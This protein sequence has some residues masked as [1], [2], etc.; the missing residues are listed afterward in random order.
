MNSIPKKLFYNFMG[1]LLTANKLPSIDFASLVKLSLKHPQLYSH[2]HASTHPCP[3]N[4]YYTSQPTLD[5]PTAPVNGSAIKPT[6]KSNPI[7]W[8]TDLL[9]AA[10][11]HH[12]ANPLTQ[13]SAPHNPKHLR[14]SAKAANYWRINDS[15][16]A[17]QPDSPPTPR[18]YT[19]RPLPTHYNKEQ[20]DRAAEAGALIDSL[21]GISDDYLCR[22]LD[23]NVYKWTNITSADVRL[24]RMLHGP[25]P[26]Y[27]AG[28]LK[29][30][31]R[32][33]STT[34]PATRPGQTLSFDP[35]IMPCTQYGGFTHEVMVVDEHTGAPFSVGT[36]SKNT[37]NV[38]VAL[39]EFIRVHLNAYGHNARR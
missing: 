31:P 2:S 36:A 8:M 21:A 13:P 34:P 23:H 18:S 10:V 32:P 14:P 9:K 25:D 35:I 39:Q 5:K 1:A 3:T 7:A 15:M 17:A 16:P 27:I 22:D 20:L 4:A 28:H 6:F 37:V 26:S 30:P 24:H 11:D 19:P 38:F 29:H 33:P 12:E